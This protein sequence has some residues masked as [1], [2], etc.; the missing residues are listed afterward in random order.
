[1]KQYRIVITDIAEIDIV[2]GK[3]WYN[4]QQNKLGDEF[5]SEIENKILVIQSNPYL[6][7]IIKKDIRKAL[8]KRFPFGIYYF[9]EGDV[10]NIF[11]VIHFSRNPKIWKQRLR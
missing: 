4:S 8:L 9:L 3:N 7:S 11:A 2:T 10:I 5:I 1:M 6:F